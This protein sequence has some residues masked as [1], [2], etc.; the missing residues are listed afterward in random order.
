MIKYNPIR[1]KQHNTWRS[2]MQSLANLKYGTEIVSVFDEYDTLR[3]CRL[4]KSNTST[5]QQCIDIELSELIG[6]GF[7]HQKDRIISKFKQLK[8]VVS[9]SDVKP[10]Y[11]CRLFN[12]INSVDFWKELEN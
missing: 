10:D 11:K 3:V 4:V 1:A 7:S 5:D 9:N 12:E 2:L 6:L 8:K